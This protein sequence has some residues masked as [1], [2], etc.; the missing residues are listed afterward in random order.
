MYQSRAYDGDDGQPVVVIVASGTHD[1]SRLAATLARG[2]CEQAALSAAV[3]RQVNRHNGGRAALALLARHGGPDLLA[4]VP[5]Y[6]P[7]TADNEPAWIHSTAYQEARSAA[8][9]IC[10]GGTPTPTVFVGLTGEGGQML[11]AYLNGAEWET[12][13]GYGDA[14]L[15]WAHHYQ[16]PAAGD[17]GEAES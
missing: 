17:D 10:P 2:V 6:P 15:N 8:I 12:T 5:D 1:V 9:T 16:P 14:S 13:V 7:A 4:P 3:T 11:G